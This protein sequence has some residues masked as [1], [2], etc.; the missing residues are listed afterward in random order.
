[1]LITNSRLKA[2]QACRRLHWY[3]YV[4]GYRPVQKAAALDF[5]TVFHAGLEGWWCAH[6]DGLG[7]QA[8]DLA[9][10]MM[11]H[12]ATEAET[13][14]AVA[15]VKA[16]LLIEAYDLRWGPTMD[17]W[18][19]LGVELEFRAPVADGVDDAGKLDLLL[20][21]R[22]DG[23]VWIGE[24]KTSG[25]DL[26]PGSTYWQ[27]LRMDSQVSMY[28]RGARTIGYQPMGC[29]YDVIVKP[30]LR[31]LKAT[32]EHLRKFTKAGALY[33]NQRAE[34]ET[35]EEFRARM[36]EAIAADPGAYFARAEVV[37]LEHELE[38]FD[39]DKAEATA[40]IRQAQLLGLKARS[41]DAC[42]KF[43]RP[44]EFLG[45]CDGTADINDPNLFTRSERIHPELSS[46]E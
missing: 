8:L 44:C 41:V 14:D 13:F 42:F 22:A 20:R 39:A 1:M 45:V 31:P 34:D 29:L 23:T 15:A 12:A 9:R 36:A 6:R 4:E 2:F 7:S 33:A 18:E 35:M 19:V 5:G 21:K 24:H 16:D 10:S 11:A 28:F 27:R 17:E 40:S 30:D 32:P 3:K 25:A 37:R 43:N 46:D 26:S 38:A